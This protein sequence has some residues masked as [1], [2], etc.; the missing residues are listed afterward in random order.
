MTFVFWIVS[1]WIY[2]ARPFVSNFAIWI[3][4]FIMLRWYVIS[5]DHCYDLRLVSCLEKSFVFLYKF[6]KTHWLFSCDSSP[7]IVSAGKNSSCI[8]F[9][10]LDEMLCQER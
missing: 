4:N 9:S 6:F 8:V 3:S 7:N 1:I 2:L 10:N 5:L